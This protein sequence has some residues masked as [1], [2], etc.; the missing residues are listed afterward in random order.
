[1]ADTRSVRPLGLIRKLQIVVSGHHFE[2]STAVLALDAP[3]AYPILLGKPWLWFANIKQNWQH[4]YISFRRGRSKVRVPTQETSAST[5]AIMPLY[6]EEIN[7]LE[8]LEDTELEAY[9]DENP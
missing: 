9:L 8:G 6:A 1:M 3:R 4:N 5:K 7:M 2:I